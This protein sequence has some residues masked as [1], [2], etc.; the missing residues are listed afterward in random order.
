MNKIKELAEGIFIFVVW[1]AI[2]WWND[3]SH[4][5]GLRLGFKY[6]MLSDGMWRRVK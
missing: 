4:A 5:V 3:V 2:I 6:R 1:N